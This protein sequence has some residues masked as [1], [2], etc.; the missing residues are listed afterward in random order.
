M[1][2][3]QAASASLSLFSG[4]LLASN[5]KVTTSEL[6]CFLRAGGKIFVCPFLG[7]KDFLKRLDPARGQK[8][9]R[10]FPTGPGNMQ[11]RVFQEARWLWYADN[12]GLTQSFN[13]YRL[14]EITAKPD[15]AG[16]DSTPIVTGGLGEQWKRCLCRWPG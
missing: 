15:T 13:I 16:R 3:L 14:A 2:A 9:F 6:G 5:V 12:N 10:I 4:P 8:S 11:G 1:S 7:S